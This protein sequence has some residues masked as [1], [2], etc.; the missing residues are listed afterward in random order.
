MLT[1]SF[2]EA[3]LKRTSD[4]SCSSNLERLSIAD[5]LGRGGSRRS[6]QVEL[7]PASDGTVVYRQAD[8]SGPHLGSAPVVSECHW[9]L[10]AR[11]PGRTS[12]SIFALS[13]RLRRCP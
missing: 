12:V 9:C 4:R 6:R 7:I 8:C 3:D 11:E 2:V 1:L 10:R 5:D 13:K